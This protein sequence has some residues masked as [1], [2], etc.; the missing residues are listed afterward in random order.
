MKISQMPTNFQ[1]VQQVNKEKIV[2]AATKQ[3]DDAKKAYKEMVQQQMAEAQKTKEQGENDPKA[4]QLM[5]KF[6]GG[7]KL[8]PEEMAYIRK[9]APEM[10]KYIDNIMQEREAMELSMKL[11]PTKTDVQMVAMNAGKQMNQYESED[12]E[13]RLRHLA[14]AKFEYEKPDQYKEKPDH[15]LDRLDNKH[16]KKKKHVI[17]Q[18]KVA[19]EQVHAY[20][21]KQPAKKIE[22]KA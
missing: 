7:E 3:I 15:L 13:V 1:P 19:Y 16:H 5:E 9:T 20:T 14:N 18:A 4:Q 12:R 8:S 10:A 17:A 2:E 21:T 22:D 11:A 6:K